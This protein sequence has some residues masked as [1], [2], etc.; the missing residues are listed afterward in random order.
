[1]GFVVYHISI[2]FYRTVTWI[3]SPF[4]EKAGKMINGRKNWKSKLSGS[5]KK[6]F[7]MHCASLG[8]FEQ[9]RPVLESFRKFHPDWY[10]LLTFFSP[11]GLDHAEDYQHADLVTYLP[12]DTRS[13][14]VHFYDIVQPDLV[15]FVKY[16]FWYHFLSEGN[17]R[18][19]PMLLISAIFRSDQLFF[20]WYGGFY[21]R[22]LRFFDQIHVQNTASAKLL[23]NID[24]NNVE[25]TGDSRIDRVIDISNQ[26]VRIPLLD[27]KEFDRKVFVI[28]SAWPVDLEVLIPV[29]ND[30]DLEMF[31]IIAP[32]EINQKQL[33]KLKG[34]LT[35]NVELY[36]EIDQSIDQE[37]DCLILDTVGLLSSLYKYGDFAYIGG[38]FGDGLHNILEP[39]VFGLPVLFGDR[40]YEKFQE[41]HD[42]LEAGGAVTVTD[43]KQLKTEVLNLINDKILMA[44]RSQA[45]KSYIFENEGATG[46]TIAKIE[47]LL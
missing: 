4:H 8:E 9:G 30:P 17:K 44:N 1:M 2:F 10:I 12:W 24:Y 37:T 5:S 46:K 25:V 7:W 22:I 31:T 41:A 16:E 39:S 47:N 15:C 23:K 40:H 27:R 18:S 38:A 20:K 21:R 29:L 26:S 43:S 34:K 13:N 36:T 14:A 3:L 28:G 42:L 33:I 32:H 35:G 11:S 19:I 45:V 6:V